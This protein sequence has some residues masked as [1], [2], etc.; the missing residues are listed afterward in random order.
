MDAFDYVNKEMIKENYDYAFVDLWHGGED[1]LALY[2]KM[3]KFE[4][5]H[6]NTKFLYWLEK[7][8]LALLRRCFL[9]ILSEQI[10]GSSDQDYKKLLMKL[11]ILLIVCIFY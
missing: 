6:K 8:I 2:L 4:H 11:M 9:T 3:N 7:S 10:D 1:G 5:Q